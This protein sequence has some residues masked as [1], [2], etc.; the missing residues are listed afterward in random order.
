MVSLSNRRNLRKSGS[1]RLRNSIVV[2]VVLTVT[3]IAIGAAH[4]YRVYQSKLPSFEQLHNIE[5]S[6]NTKIYDRNGILLKEFF[7]ENR[8]LTPLDGIPPHLREMCMASEDREFYKHW[9]LHLRG[10]DRQSAQLGD[11]SRCVHYHPTA[12]PHALLDTE[13]DLRA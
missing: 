8:V 7:S 5:P 1:T 9:G 4:T 3:L 11:Q 2:L 6:L 13:A 12:R 10:C